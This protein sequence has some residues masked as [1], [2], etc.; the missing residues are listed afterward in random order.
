MICGIIDI[1]ANTIRLS[2][3]SVEGNDARLLLNKKE[4]AGLA[5]YVKSKKLSQ[6]GVERACSVLNDFKN[7]LINLGIT[8]YH[9]FATASLRNISNTEEAVLYIRAHTG[10]RV[11]VISGEEEARLGFA[12][13]CRDTGIQNGM[14]IDVGGGSTEVVGFKCGSVTAAS[15][16]PVGSLNLFSKHVKKLLPSENELRNISI[17]I[18]EQLVLLHGYGIAPIRKIIGIGGTVRAAAK[19]Q[20]E[21]FGYTE[22]SSLIRIE[23][24]G[25]LLK[26]YRD[27]DGRVMKAILLVAP[28]RVHTLIPGLDIMFNVA[29]YFG[30]ETITANKCSVR[31]GYVNSRIIEG[32]RENAAS[33]TAGDEIYAE[34]GTVVAEIQ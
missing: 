26:H 5:S 24:I 20:N 15:S 19:L 28:E 4:T 32:D 31:E 27:R 25:Q 17:D 16:M 9:A 7:I 14:M 12:G 21:Y 18:I 23:D 8:D 29:Q 6:K 1:G 2:I 34:Q 13:A 10:I 22:D 3:Y 11:D 33:E 30:A